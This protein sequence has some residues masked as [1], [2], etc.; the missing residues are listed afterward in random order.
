[1]SEFGVVLF[2]TSSAAFRG[3]KILRQA[4][5]RV[6]MVPT[7]RQFSSNCGFALRFPWA[8]AEQVRA[9]LEAARV[10]TEKLHPL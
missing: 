5:L 7:P 10:E 6:K 8:A 2:H 9:L 4:A 3:E 1:M